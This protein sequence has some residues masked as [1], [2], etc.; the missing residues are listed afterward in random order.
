MVSIFTNQEFIS[1]TGHADDFPETPINVLFWSA[2]LTFLMVN[3]QAS[4]GMEYDTVK[5]YFYKFDYIENRKY[6]VMYIPHTDFNYVS[7][8]VDY[9][10]GF[11]YNDIENMNRYMGAI[12]YLSDL[13]QIY[14]NQVYIIDEEIHNIEDSYRY[15]VDLFQVYN[16]SVQNI[17]YRNLT[18]DI[19]EIYRSYMINYM[20]YSLYSRVKNVKN[21]DKYYYV[22][23]HLFTFDETPV[24]YSGWGDDSINIPAFM[25]FY[26][27]ILFTDELKNE[28]V[29][30]YEDI[31]D[32][33]VEMLEYVESKQKEPVFQQPIFKPQFGPQL[34]PFGGPQF[35]PQN[36]P[37]PAFGQQQPVQPPP[38]QIQHVQP[39]FGQPQ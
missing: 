19:D 37:Q 6:V 2:M 22:F 39:P 33:S 25:S 16:K 3:K 11:G 20:R 34:Q 29:E 21:K 17:G 18:S 32:N 36:L 30:Y 27:S 8:H 1:N 12:N 15:I 26:D 38:P 28:I 7:T 9:S 35:A 23:L 13:I 4:L 24:E 31:Q 10:P 14:Y 5:E